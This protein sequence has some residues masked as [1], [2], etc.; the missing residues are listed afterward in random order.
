MAIGREA[1]AHRGYA[2]RH[3]SVGL[4]TSVTDLNVSF[5]TIPVTPQQPGVGKKIFVA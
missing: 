3:W 5:P 2:H 1:Q 4:T